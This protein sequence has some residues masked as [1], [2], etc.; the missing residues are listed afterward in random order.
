MAEAEVSAFL[1][2]LAVERQVSA[3]TQNQALNALV[4]MYKHVVGKPLGDVVDAVRAKRP[5][6]LPV[7][8][9][10]EEVGRL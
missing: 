7:V 8:L 10:R 3:A 2:W 1:S 9:T 6:R 4:F 5:R